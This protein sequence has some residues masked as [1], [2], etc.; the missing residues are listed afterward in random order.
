MNDHPHHELLHAEPA[1]PPELH[2]LL[3]YLSDAAALLDQWTPQR[4]RTDRHERQTADRP[5]ADPTA[6]GGR[7]RLHHPNLDGEGPG[8]TETYERT[9]SDAAQLRHDIALCATLRTDARSQWNT[10]TGEAHG[11]EEIRIALRGAP[12]HYV[13]C[14]LD[15]DGKPYH[16]VAT[17]ERTPE[18]EDPDGARTVTVTVNRETERLLQML[19]TCVSPLP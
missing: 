10:W 6:E 14:P 15:S 18:D 5:H 11:P 8:Y 9:R 16:A 12:G 4:G 2:A 19:A 13:Q 1:P 3:R 7:V 17:L